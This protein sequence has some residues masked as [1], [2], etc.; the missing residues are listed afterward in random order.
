MDFSSPSSLEE[1]TQQQSKD[2]SQPSSTRDAPHSSHYNYY[3]GRDAHPRH[4][5]SRIVENVLVLQGG[6][7]LGAFGCGV[8]KS[9]ARQGKKFDIVAG[10]SIGAVNAAIIAGSKSGHPEKDLENFWIELAESSYDIIPDFILP[11][12][13]FA[14]GQFAWKRISAAAINAGLFGVPKMFVPRM[15]SWTQFLGTSNGLS[16][17]EGLAMTPEGW[18]YLYDHTPLGRTLEEYVDFDRL[19]PQPQSEASGQTRLI[20]TCVDVLTSKHL[21]YDSH[22]TKIDAKHILASTAYPNYGFPWIET[23]REVYGWDGALMDNTPL[24]EVIEASPRNDKHVY[25]VE[26]YPRVRRRLPQNRVEVSDRARDITFSD[27]TTHDI[28][29]AKR[30]TRMIELV[31]H[32]YDVLEK[33]T[34]TSKLTREE[35]AHIKGDYHELVE[36]GGAEILSVNRIVRTEMDSPYPLK[37]ADFSLGTVTEL[38]RQGEENANRALSL[39]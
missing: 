12:Y 29:T 33:H 8:F 32:I 19:S 15:W 4:R 25:I 9:L 1:K 30:M 3:L 18:T 14:T 26:N 10:T 20:L 13:D 27:K 34:N 17:D 38:I 22:K 39:V 16:V 7:S 24:R 11:Q 2:D 6:G 31:E 23:D 28:E 5:R 21:V 37:N 36:S 35:I